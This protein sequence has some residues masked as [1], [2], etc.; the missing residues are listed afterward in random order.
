MA[1]SR[2]DTKYNTGTLIQNSQ[3]TKKDE[4]K[5]MNL[6]KNNLTATVGHSLTL[7][8]RFALQIKEKMR[9]SLLIYSHWLFFFYYFLN[10]NVMKTQKVRQTTKSA[11]FVFHDFPHDV[12]K[13][14]NILP[15]PQGMVSYHWL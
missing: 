5:I 10:I 15:R 6:T 13:Q 11:L 4:T 12:H 1:N 14:A 9:T 8:L 3:E 7:W 2:N